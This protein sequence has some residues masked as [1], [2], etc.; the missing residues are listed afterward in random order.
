V[1]PGKPIVFDDKTE[2]VFHLKGS[3]L[4]AVTDP[5]ELKRIARPATSAGA[6]G[7]SS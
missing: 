3:D 5:K 6:A 1:K 7:T 2:G 4:V